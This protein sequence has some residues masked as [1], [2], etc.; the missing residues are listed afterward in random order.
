M[1]KKLLSLFLCFISILFINNPAMAIEKNQTIID[2]Y[3]PEL[4]S[5]MNISSESSEPVY[6]ARERRTK[7]SGTGEMSWAWIGSIF[8]TGLGQIL[9]GEVLRGLGF[10]AAVILGGVLIGVVGG[11]S[12]P[13]IATYALVMQIWSVFDAYNIAKRQAEGSDEEARLLNEKLAQIE[14][15]LDKLSIQNNK[16]SYNLASF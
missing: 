12:N 13:L 15:A 10:L 14:K 11:S 1:F 4:T 3:K 6:L 16:L 7:D 8:I 5:F 9:L 2:N